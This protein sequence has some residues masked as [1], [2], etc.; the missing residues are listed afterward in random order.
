VY[1]RSGKGYIEIWLKSLSDDTE[2]MITRVDGTQQLDAIISPN[3]ERIGYRAGPA[4]AR[5]GFVV[6]VS[7][8]VPARV[9]QGCVVFGFLSDNRRILALDQKAT[10]LRAIDVRSGASRELLNAPNRRFDRTHLSPDDRLLTFRSGGEIYVVAVPEEGPAPEHA[11]TRIEQVVPDGR[12]CGWSLDS[13]TAYLLLNTDGF[14]CLWGQRIDKASGRPVGP[15]MV[16]RHFHDTLAQE[17]STS[18]GD[19]ITADGFLYGGG[20]LTANLWRLPASAR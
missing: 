15:P 16:V 8:G 12:P 17:F 6:E 1:E 11:W 5:D 19:A 3:G 18:I 2:R 14:R 7:G 10:R 9:C 13:T 4:E 20:V